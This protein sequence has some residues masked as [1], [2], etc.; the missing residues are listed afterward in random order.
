MSLECNV[1]GGWGVRRMMRGEIREG[2]VILP[3]GIKRLDF[4]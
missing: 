4:I 3:R 1:N 2:K